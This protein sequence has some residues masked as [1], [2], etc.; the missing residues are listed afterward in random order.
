MTSPEF[1]D[2]AAPKN[3][4]A[5]AIAAGALIMLGSFLPWVTVHAV[6]LGSLNKNGT[7]GDGII[8]L[9]FGLAM[10]LY[11]VARLVTRGLPK[12]F[13]IT[14]FAIAVVTA[15]IALY[16]MVDV[17]SHIG[18]LQSEA[19]GLV[20]ADIGVGL[21]IVLIGAI[22]AA[23]AGVLLLSERTEPIAA[24]AVEPA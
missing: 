5:L 1:A 18:D 2:P 13:V 23:A 14:P 20:T 3:G 19:E 16:D 12:V 6:F 17:Q 4:G 11:G 24:P 8:T 9:L 7:E 15:A 22:L 21:W 10:F